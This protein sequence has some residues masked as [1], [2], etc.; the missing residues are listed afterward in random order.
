MIFRPPADYGAGG[1]QGPDEGARISIAT[2]TQLYGI[3]A[4]FA[5]AQSSKSA[6]CLRKLAQ[7]DTAR[8]S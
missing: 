8:S 7:N 4:Q 5:T 6:P 1:L 3:Y 2:T